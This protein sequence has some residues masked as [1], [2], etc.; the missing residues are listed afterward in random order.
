MF[1]RLIFMRLLFLFPSA[2]RILFQANI[3]PIFALGRELIKIKEA[4]R[5]THELPL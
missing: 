4:G 2:R 3:M 5:G 1:D